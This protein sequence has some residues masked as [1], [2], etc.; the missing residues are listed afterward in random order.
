M[1]T[2]IGEPIVPLLFNYAFLMCGESTRLMRNHPGESLI[3]FRTYT[4]LYGLTRS[5]SGFVGQVSYPSSMLAMAVRILQKSR[6]DGPL[7]F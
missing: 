6:A 2:I 7:F 1:Y 3:D 5:T 4:R